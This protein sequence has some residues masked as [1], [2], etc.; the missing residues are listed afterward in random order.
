MRPPFVSAA[1]ESFEKAWDQTAPRAC[2]RSLEW[3][4]QGSASLPASLGAGHEGSDISEAHDEEGNGLKEEVDEVVVPP[5][6]QVVARAEDE[7]D[8]HP[9]FQEVQSG[10]A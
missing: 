10:D 9:E 8:S 4:E 6:G 5:E 1:G 2:P 7:E 3:N